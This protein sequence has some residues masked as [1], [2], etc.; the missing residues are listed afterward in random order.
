MIN[1]N[2]FFEKLMKQTLKRNNTQLYKKKNLLVFLIAR[3]PDIYLLQRIAQIK[4]V[5]PSVLLRV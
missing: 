2:N 1:G 5:S 3:L 4:S